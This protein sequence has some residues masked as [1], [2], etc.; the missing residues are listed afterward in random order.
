[1][2]DLNGSFAKSCG[3]DQLKSYQTPFPATFFHYR[4]N[5]GFDSIRVN[6]QITFA[7]QLIT[8]DGMSPYLAWAAVLG[9]ENKDLPELL[10]LDQGQC[11]RLLENPDR[12][13]PT[14]NVHYFCNKAGVHPAFLLPETND[15]NYVFHYPVLRAVARVYKDKSLSPHDRD[16]A[17]I[18]LQRE[19]EKFE[20]FKKTNPLIFNYLRSA[21][22][23]VG[24]ISDKAIASPVAK[25]SW[26]F[27]S[28]LFNGGSFAYRSK[29]PASDV[30]LGLRLVQENM[31]G[32][33]KKAIKKI[34]YERRPA[35]L[36]D[37]LFTSGSLIYG[38]KHAP[39]IIN[40]TIDMISFHEKREA[41]L[42]W[43]L[44]SNGEWNKRN[45]LGQDEILPA[46][47]LPVGFEVFVRGEGYKPAELLRHFERTILLRVMCD[48]QSEI[49]KNALHH[50]D[51]T[52]EMFQAWR[53]GY[54]ANAIHIPQFAN[55]VLAA[56]ALDKS[57][58]GLASI[59]RPK[60]DAPVRKKHDYQY[61]MK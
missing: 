8:E 57:I 59:S 52:L 27:H 40:A 24:Q 50:Y 41:G 31:Q 11:D 7:H 17:R 1:M 58:G 45:K 35:A 46:G 38:D 18:C 42:E 4:E 25:T 54:A 28:K 43:S 14:H 26:D 53:D 5:Y 55:Y 6:E 21:M 32:E 2:L 3:T 60:E 33:I 23:N 20:S 51:H 36:N 48:L 22:L 34:E 61:S 47:K 30:E 10:N 12:S 13:P 15:E 56:R 49:N 44:L 37:I 9:Y 16:I 19:Y 39:D 29:N